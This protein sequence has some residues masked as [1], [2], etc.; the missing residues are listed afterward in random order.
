[1]ANLLYSEGNSTGKVQNK[2][3][4]G[5]VRCRICVF[6]SLNKYKLDKILPSQ[7][8]ISL[9]FSFLNAPVLLCWC[10]SYE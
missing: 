5:I 8:L 10:N 2:L 9:S 6:Y 7:S 3:M 4:M 1:M